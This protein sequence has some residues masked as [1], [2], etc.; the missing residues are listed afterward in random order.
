MRIIVDEA[1]C[2]AELFSLF[3]NSSWLLGDHY[4]DLTGALSHV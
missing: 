1:A 3:F 2:T 4:S